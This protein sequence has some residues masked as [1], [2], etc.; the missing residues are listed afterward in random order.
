VSP[1]ISV[2]MIF[3]NAQ[4]YFEEAIESVLTQN[5]PSF[6][7]VLVDDG[8][9]DRSPE[10]AEKYAASHPERVRCVRHPDGGNHGMSAA[11]A[12]GIDEARGRYIAFLDADDRWEPDHLALQH[13]ALLEHPGA[14]WVAARCRTWQSWLD[15][16][17]PDPETRLGFEPGTIVQPPD[18][19]TAVLR[20]GGTSVPICSMLVPR[21][22]LREL[23]GPEKSFRSLY[24]DQALQAK[25]YLAAPVVTIAP[26]TAWYRQHPESACSV[27]ERTGIDHGDRPSLARR[28]Y[29]KWLR[30]YATA[31]TDDP[32]LLAALSQAEA[33]FRFGPVVTATRL[34]AIA[35]EHLP[36][37]VYRQL[38]R[39]RSLSRRLR[40]ADDWHVHFGTLR[41][42]TPVA[43]QFGAERGLPVDR[44]FIESF[45]HRNRAYITG[46]VL[47]VGEDTYTRR[48]GTGVDT[49]D[50]L[51]VDP[52]AAEATI[53]ADLADAPHI[54]AE[55]F[56]C[57]IVTQ[58]LQLVYDLQ[59][60]VR[61]M[62][63]ILKPGGVVLATVP[64]ITQRDDPRWND[65]WYW[66]FSTKSTARLFGD[67]FG[68]DQVRVQAHGNVF[69][70]IC[71][72]EGIAAH[73]LE[74]E[75][76]DWHDPCYEML[77]SVAA[78]KPCPPGPE[79]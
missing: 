28:E 36:R 14:A 41:R 8:S 20:D 38:R 73:E 53:V 19:L 74:F 75:E 66:S 72:L 24:E 6:E 21:A 31:R 37:P 26:I 18:Y 11:R 30:P 17:L 77:I 48:F 7:V 10:I 62:Y 5:H 13:D 32:D 56:D 27:A 33:P 64:G 35:R 23:G 3:Y 47:E 25:L 15:P 52:S 61:T 60:A 16:R 78:E 1:D 45:L 4:R 44:Y 49:I 54:P 63:R 42:L 70:S 40:K 58:T 39:A 55:S 67:C 51:H 59:A 69:T 29:L 2:V 71:F 46:N 50:V 43:P 9:T 12:L 22:L 57:I 79:T 68:D 65:T 76:L 34:R